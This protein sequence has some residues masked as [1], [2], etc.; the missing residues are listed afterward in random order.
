MCCETEERGTY[1]QSAGQ[2]C[3]K[4]SWTFNCDE[5]AD[6]KAGERC[7]WEKQIASCVVGECRF[8]RDQMCSRDDECA[9]SGKC[10]RGSMCRGESGRL[11]MPGR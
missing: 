3:G 11:K 6:C 7:C 1:C 5:T 8:E 2:T 9:A 10:L 4:R